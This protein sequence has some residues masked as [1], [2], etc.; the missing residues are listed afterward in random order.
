MLSSAPIPTGLLAYGMS[1][2]LFH[3]PFLAAHP[4]FELYA[5]VERHEARMAADYPGVRSYPSMTEFLA[6]P[7]LELVVIN[8]PNGLHVEQAF[9]GERAFAEEILINLRAG[10]AVRVD[11]ALAG[12]QPV[13]QR[14]VFLCRQ[15]RGHVRLQ[16]AVAMLDAAAV[17]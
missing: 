9:A 12:E 1:G 16:D 6:D 2:K 3:A 15:R 14:D 10:D 7:A 13:I 5:V 11:P 4:G 8:T 17:G